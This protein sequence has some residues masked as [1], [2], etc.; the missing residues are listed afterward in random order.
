MNQLV[1]VVWN[2]ASRVT[3]LGPQRRKVYALPKDCVHCATGR[4]ASDVTDG[5]G[6]VKR[7]HHFSLQD[8]VI[9]QSSSSTGRIERGLNLASETA[10]R[11]NRADNASP[12]PRLT[13]RVVCR[14]SIIAQSYGR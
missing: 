5:G 10:R 6:L 11:R 12:L 1:Y 2:R 7:A 3:A 4:A 13:L 8:R 9:R 14:Q